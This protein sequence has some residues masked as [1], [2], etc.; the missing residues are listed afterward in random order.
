MSE[1]KQSGS[2]PSEVAMWHKLSGTPDNVTDEGFVVDRAEGRR[3]QAEKD[4]LRSEIQRLRE[5]AGSS[6]A[7]S[8]ASLAG[9]YLLAGDMETARRYANA[10]REALAETRSEGDARTE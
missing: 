8:L 9:S 6:R 5:S 7:R 3:Q 1:K 10:A 4:A 2:E